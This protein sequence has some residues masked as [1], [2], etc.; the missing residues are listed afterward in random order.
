MDKGK[1]RDDHKKKAI[2]D[3]LVPVYLVTRDPVNDRL[4]FFSQDSPSFFSRSHVTDVAKVAPRTSVFLISGA[5]VY[6]C[7]WVI[8]SFLSLSLSLSLLV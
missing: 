6:Q 8:M 1:R 3:T 4:F 7:Q 2:K 5:L